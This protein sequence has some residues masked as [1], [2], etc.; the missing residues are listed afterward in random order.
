MGLMDVI[1]GVLN[2]PRGQRQ[3][4]SREGGGGMSPMMMA[5]LALLAYK[6]LKGRKGAA[7]AGAPQQPGP[8][9]PTA[10]QVPDGAPSGGL[11]NILGGLLG[12]RTGGAGSG[13]GLQ[14]LMKGGLGGLLA[15]ATAGSVVSGGLDNLIKEF[16]DRGHGNAAQS[17]IGTGPNQAISPNDLEN[18]L[19][20]ET[21]DTIAQQTGMSRS[22]LLA[23][24]SNHLPELVDQLTPHGR[25]PTPEEAAQTV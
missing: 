18:V 14:D 4:S 19:G 20:S 13:A 15:G 22:E 11:G 10:S 6:A 17:W 8:I 2:G 5:L 24:L 12:G 25:I 16:Q 23:G 9:G 1:N 21:L 3:P 7:H